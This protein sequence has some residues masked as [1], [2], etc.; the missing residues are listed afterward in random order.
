MLNVS[1]LS[2]TAANEANFSLRLKYM[3]HPT[4]KVFVQIVWRVRNVVGKIAQI[5]LSHVKPLAFLC[6]ILCDIESSSG[7]P[8]EFGASSGTSLY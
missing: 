1:G 7:M 3:S 4:A 8:H 2:V 6:Y 5:D